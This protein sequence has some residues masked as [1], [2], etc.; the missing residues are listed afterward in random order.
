MSDKAEFVIL[1]MTDLKWLSKVWR[2]GLSA[3]GEQRRTGQ[4]S[5]MSQNDC[6]LAKGSGGG[7]LRTK[8]IGT[9]QG[10]CQW[11]RGTMTG[12][13]P[14]GEVCSPPKGLSADGE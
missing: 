8:W 2:A 7:P 14:E 9:G 4:D 10:M 5:R 1:L 6:F 12:C 11:D 3:D 13:R